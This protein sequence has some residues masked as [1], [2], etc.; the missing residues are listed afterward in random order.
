MIVAKFVVV[1]PF[2]DTVQSSWRDLDR[3]VQ[4]TRARV[5]GRLLGGGRGTGIRVNRSRLN[6]KRDLGR[7]ASISNRSGIASC[8]VRRRRR[9]RARGSRDVAVGDSGS[10]DRRRS[11]QWSDAVAKRCL[12]Y[13]LLRSKDLVVEVQNVDASGNEL[14]NSGNAFNDGNTALLGLVLEELVEEWGIAGIMGDAEDK[15]LAVIVA[16]I[17]FRSFCFGQY[18]ST[19]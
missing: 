18:P 1:L 9:G 7:G 12:V 19:L 2:L 14:A 8:R 16:Q 13:Q 4:A 17:P 3:R 10:V 5:P 6:W 15:L 11:S